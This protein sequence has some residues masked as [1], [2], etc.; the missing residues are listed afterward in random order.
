[1]TETYDPTVD[2][3]YGLKVWALFLAFALPLS[4]VVPGIA[5]LA[6]GLGSLAAS[7]HVFRVR[8]HSGSAKWRLISFATLSLITSVFF[9]AAWCFGAHQQWLLAI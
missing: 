3:R 1:M 7:E 9:A 8:V 2:Y 5:M 4:V 6:L